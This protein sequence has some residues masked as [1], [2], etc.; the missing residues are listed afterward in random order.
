MDGGRK[1]KRSQ[2]SIIEN[3]PNYRVLQYSRKIKTAG[4]YLVVVKCDKKRMCRHWLE[5]LSWY[6]VAVP[7]TEGN[8]IQSS[9]SNRGV[10]STLARKTM[11]PFHKNAGSGT[12]VSGQVESGGSMRGMSTSTEMSIDSARG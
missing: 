10:P 1:V 6:Q 12:F 3:N 9:S 5:C 7:G 11:T 4:T 2:D 8:H